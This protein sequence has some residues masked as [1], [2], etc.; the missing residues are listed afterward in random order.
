[1]IRAHQKK[2]AR[3]VI[4]ARWV[5]KWKW[6]YPTV[7]A[8]SS[9]KAEPVKVIRAR[10][11]LRGFKDHDKE[12]IAKYAGTS[13]RS[14]QKILVSEAVR[15]GWDVCTT[16]ISKA[17]LQGVTYKELAQLTGEP[18]REVNFYLP[19]YNIPMLRQ[20]KGFE[21]FDPMHE[22]LHSDKPGTGLVDA[23]RAFSLKLKHKHKLYATT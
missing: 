1:M 6:E 19:G 5:L 2:H 22:V 23:P 9:A 10:L 18:M 17:F 3:N 20:L 14:S 21:D 4:D 15:N 7:D 16:D 12:E 11:C 8:S 13:A